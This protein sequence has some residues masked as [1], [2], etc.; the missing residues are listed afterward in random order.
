M[1]RTFHQLQEEGDQIDN[2]VDPDLIIPGRSN[3]RYQ[4]RGGSTISRS[5][6]SD[7]PI[8]FTRP[9]A[10]MNN[11]LTPCPEC[12]VTVGPAHKCDIC[13]RNIHVF[14]GTPVGEEQFGQSVRCRQC[15]IVQEMNSCPTT[16]QRR[17][18]TTT[19]PHPPTTQRQASTPNHDGNTP[20]C[21]ING[22]TPPI[23]VNT[24]TRRRS[25][26]TTGTTCVALPTPSPRQII[27]AAPR[28]TIAENQFQDRLE[29]GARQ[30]H[31]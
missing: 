18:R 29:E 31:N 2:Y 9:P 21:P 4:N 3:R 20:L 8:F 25:R 16:M 5:R 10:G 28:T 11:T 13:K 15:G 17:P 12:Q 27:A 22:N 14:C 30:L 7:D 26:S 24:A 19:I 1:S 23:T 6:G